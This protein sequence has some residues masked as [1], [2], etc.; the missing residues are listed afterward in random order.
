MKRLLA[1]L[2]VSGALLGGATIPV[3]S[4]PVSMIVAAA[5]PCSAYSKSQYTTVSEV[6]ATSTPSY[7]VKNWDYKPSACSTATGT[8]YFALV[9]DDTGTGYYIDLTQTQYQDMGKADGEKQNPTSIDQTLLDLLVPAANAAIAVD[10]ADTT[11][12]TVS[13]ASSLTYAF[14]NAA[15]NALAVCS[16]TADNTIPI[17]T[18]TYNAVSLTSSVTQN[19]SS[20]DLQGWTVGSPATGS[21]NIVVST[22]GSAVNQIQSGAISFSGANAASPLGDTATHAQQTGGAGASE[23]VTIATTHANEYLVTCWQQ[24][25]AFTAGISM[26]GTNETSTWLRS[27]PSRGGGFS[28]IPTTTTGNYTSTF[29]TTSPD[30]PALITVI[31][32][33]QV[34]ASGSSPTDDEAW[35]FGAGL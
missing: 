23:S 24:G 18:V 30:T 31:W 32:A 16:E 2:A 21:H 20:A 28:R 10:T 17:A 13:S 29:Q 33:I 34:A 8:G 11:N 35:W 25:G 1:G 6:S 22:S 3:S 27:T 4:V 26:T 15:G 5:V 19:S 12:H 14:N 9:K 7:Q